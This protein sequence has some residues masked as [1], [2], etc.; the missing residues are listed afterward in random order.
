MPKHPHERLN[1]I[2]RRPYMKFTRIAKKTTRATMT[3]GQWLTAV[4][5][6]TPML[7]CNL[8]D[9]GLE[10]TAPDKIETSVLETPANAGLLVSSAIG[11]FE[12]ALKSYVVDAAMA[13]GE[14]MDATA[15]AA[16]WPFDRRDTD[17]TADT[18]Y[19]T[20]GCDVYGIYTPI[21]IALG[22]ADR[23]LEL[24]Q[25][26]SDAQV[27]NRQDLIAKAAAY[28]G[29]SRIL[30][31]EGFCSAAINLSPEMTSAEIFA[32]AEAMFSTA[33]TAAQAAGDQQILNMAYVGRARARLDQGNKT[34]AAADAALVPSGFVMDASSENSPTIRRNR[35]QDFNQAGLVSVAPSYRNLTLPASGGG[36]VPDTRVAVTNTGRNGTDNRTPLYVQTKYPV[37]TS[38]LPIASYKEA[39]LIV[40]E[41]AGGQT[42]VNIINALRTARGLPTFSST[43]PVAIAAEV[44]EARRRELFLEG[45][46]LFDVRRLNLPLDPA[47]GI[48][49]STVYLKGGNYGT[50]RCFPVPDVER[51]NNPNF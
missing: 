13:S 16:N 26:W 20:N 1:G 41:V 47:P 39:Q 4:V 7:G 49:Y 23:T 43:D 15:T 30:L 37:S 3:A 38:P 32:S 44:T 33:I 45:Q 11:N 36:T 29:Y 8:L 22:T 51:L 50:E 48:P 21:Q 18:R 25:G 10:A 6:A 9:K 27:V 2:I 17:P 24:L 42:A 35:V 31:G 40:A 46:H 14:F 28:A 12:C 19:A 34:G 5:L